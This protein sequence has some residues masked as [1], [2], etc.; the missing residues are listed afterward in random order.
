[1]TRHFSTSLSVALFIVNVSPI[2]EGE[3][4]R[5]KWLDSKALILKSRKELV[6]SL[7]A[8]AVVTAAGFAIGS[9]SLA[10]A[11]DLSQ[12]PSAAETAFLKENDAAMTKMMNDM[13]VKPTG[14]VN[15]DFVSMMAPH[16][17]R[18]IDMSEAELRYGHNEQLI[19]IAQDIVVEELQE[20]A[21]MRV[22]SGEK[23]TPTEATLAASFAGTA[24]GPGFSSPVPADNVPPS[25]KTERS[26]LAENAAAITKMMNDMTIK[27]TANI[28]RDFV[29]MM[30]PHHQG[31]I[32]MAKAE[33]RYGHQA[34]LRRIAQEIIVD[35]IQQISLMRLA[36]GEPLPPPISS[37]TGPLPQPLAGSGSAAMST[38][39]GGGF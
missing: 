4:I 10:S 31:A 21:A 3:T 16:H 18:A 24:T 12:R 19:R 37:P 1:M 36:V 9:A 15:H 29:A 8:A 34:Q 25:L 2:L 11:Q 38:A 17:Q 27:P 28:D 33:L 39:Q 23:L 6:T 14:D 30:V 22:A 20:I 13:A 32:D 7:V 5:F 26:F 35:Q